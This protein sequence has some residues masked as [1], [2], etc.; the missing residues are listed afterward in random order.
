MHELKSV[1]FIILTIAKIAII[2]R[3]I[4]LIVKSLRMKDGRAFRHF[5]MIVVFMIVITGLEYIIAFSL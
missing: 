5:T 4:V 3:G 2:I 1:I